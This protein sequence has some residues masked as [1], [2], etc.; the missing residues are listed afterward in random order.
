MF[1]RIIIQKAM[2]EHTYEIAVLAADAEVQ[3]VNQDNI[4]VAVDGGKFFHDYVG[5][6]G[7]MGE[8]PREVAAEVDVLAIA[9]EWS[10]FMSND[11]SFEDIS[12]YMVKDC[13][14]YEVAKKY[15]NS[16]DRKF[17]SSHTLLDPA[18]TDS[19]VKH[20]V[21]IADNCFSVD[22]SFVKRMALK[23]GRK[24][25]DDMNDR[26]F[27]VKWDDTA[28]EVDNPTWKIV[29]MKEIVSHEE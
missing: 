3:V 10:L 12:A 15:A 16:V 23:S 9:Q 19:E 5:Q 21:W 4:A 22:I 2:D 14:Q 11:R 6:T 13:Y 24:V 7:N 27:F 1:C 28:D 25:E 26:F 20:F 8:V 17:F 18:F 29:S